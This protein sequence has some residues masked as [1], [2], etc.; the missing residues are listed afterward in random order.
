MYFQIRNEF[1]KKKFFKTIFDYYKKYK[2]IPLV[3]LH[4]HTNWT[5]GKN[6][7][8]EMVLAANKLKLETILFSEHSRSS[9]KNWFNKFSKEVKN[10][11]KKKMY[12]ISWNRSKNKRF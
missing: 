6:S 2:K 3:D 1:S 10:Q 7:V 12:A 11:N 5:D 8:K 4:V 9:S